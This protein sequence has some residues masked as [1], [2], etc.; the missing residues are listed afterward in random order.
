MAQAGKG[1]SMPAGFTIQGRLLPSDNTRF[2][3]KSASTLS[4]LKL[5]SVE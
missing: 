1:F 4:I 3:E 5:V 2:G